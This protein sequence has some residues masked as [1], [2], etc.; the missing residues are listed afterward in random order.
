LILKRRIS[1]IE[2]RMKQ[3]Y[4]VSELPFPLIRDPQALPSPGQMDDVEVG[5]EDWEVIAEV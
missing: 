5:E 4:S 1:I 2:A 3:E